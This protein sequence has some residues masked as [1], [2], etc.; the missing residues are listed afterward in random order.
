MLNVVEN[1]VKK[2]QQGGGSYW[3]IILMG[4]LVGVFYFIIAKNSELVAMSITQT[5]YHRTKQSLAY[6][7]DFMEGDELIGE[8][9]NH[10]L[11]H[12]RIELRSHFY[13]D[14][15]LHIVDTLLK[16]TSRP[17]QT[18]YYVVGPTVQWS[19]GK[20]AI[21]AKFLNSRKEKLL[22]QFPEYETGTIDDFI[23]FFEST[24]R[25]KEVLFTNSAE[26]ISLSDF[27]KQVELALEVIRD[28]KINPPVIVFEDFESLFGIPN[29]DR[30]V[31]EILNF[32][33]VITIRKLAHVVIV[34]TDEVFVHESMTRLH[35]LFSHK[36]RVLYSSYANAT[37]SVAFLE[38]KLNHLQLEF[39][40]AEKTRILKLCMGRLAD[41]EKIVYEV[42]M[43]NYT[44]EV[45][46]DEFLK[47]TRMRVFQAL[48]RGVG[49]TDPKKP[50]FC[51][52]KE[53]L[54]KAMKIF[55]RHDAIPYQEFVLTTMNGSLTAAKTLIDERFLSLASKS[56]LGKKN[57][58]F[59]TP[60]LST[61]LEVFR[62]YTSQSYC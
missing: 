41:I 5:I 26:K 47:S 9:V 54:C 25:R 17:P 22:L 24:I 3:T 33:F 21:M 11:N 57:Q 30:L 35:G 49:C 15:N 2:E 39:T 16:E 46:I 50:N 43:F 42:K 31:K 29:S 14:L 61:Y 12:P 40:E 1:A 4:T 20:H 53:L 13:T 62:E 45:E 60:Y 51:C 48:I 32:A 55:E 7:R 37:Q 18:I 27:L 28:R 38:E 6:I 23:N 19:G 10:I 36:S 34:T 56:L 59:V 44:L 58:V 52:P 8:I